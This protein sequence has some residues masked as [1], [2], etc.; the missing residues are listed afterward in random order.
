MRGESGDAGKRGSGAAFQRIAAVVR[1][2][3]GMP[4]YEAHVRHLKEN[5]PG[6]GI[7]GRREFYERFIQSRYGNGPTRCC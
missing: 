7:P 6:H 1:R 3:A 2:I 5:H 4:D